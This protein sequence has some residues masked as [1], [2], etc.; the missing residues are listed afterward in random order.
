M[1]SSTQIGRTPRRGFTLIELLVVIAII[2]ILIGLL[3]PAVQK[4][5][6]AAARAKCTNNLKQWALALHGFHDTAG[7]FPYGSSP[8]GIQPNS[9]TGGWGPS[10]MI[11]L[12]PNVEQNSMYQKFDMGGTGTGGQFWNSPNCPLLNGFKP[13]ILSCPSSPLPD[14]GG[15]N[16]LA[17][18]TSSNSNY[19]G[20]AGALNDPSLK[21]VFA[22]SATTPATN[23]TGN[24]VNGSGVLTISGAGKIKFASITDGTSNTLAI[25][26]NG[27]FLFT[28]NGTKRDIR[29]SQPHGF[30]MGYNSQIAPSATAVNGDNRSFNVTTIRYPINQKRGWADNDS[31]T[32]TPFGVCTNSG[33]NIPLNSAH[34][35]GVN[36][37]LAD[38][39]VRFLRDSMALAVL[40]QAALR[41]DGTVPNLD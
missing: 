20:I 28:L 37:A 10:W 25:S 13:A 4:V 19:V 1:H 27:D 21:Y 2:A 8:G 5:R 30:S 39:S 34:T 6:E 31:C 26:E 9:N 35:G 12:L 41:D 22:T 11:H 29:G 17:N 24:V 7:Q 15:G 23:S 33:A 38:G 18:G 40:Q 32:T 16:N 3:L 36:A 14:D